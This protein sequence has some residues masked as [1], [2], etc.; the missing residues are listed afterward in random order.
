MD[1]VSGGHADMLV[2]ESRLIDP[3]DNFAE[4]FPGLGF[5]DVYSLRTSGERVLVTDPIYLADVY[6]STDEVASYLRRRGVF[7]KEFGGD[8]SCPVW[9][10]EPFVKL[11][12]MGRWQEDNVSLPPGVRVLAQEVGTDS[13]SFIFLPL[14][15][16]MPRSVAEAIDLVL[17]EDNGAA[18]ELSAGHWRVLYE[19]MDAPRP[20]LAGLSRNIVLAHEA[21]IMG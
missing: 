10:R 17:R 21:R 4:A 1:H 20:D 6:N 12:I 3:R 8:G 15:A 16:G 9:W 13:G 19:Q 14:E 18:L 11:P 5:R 2:D 7:V